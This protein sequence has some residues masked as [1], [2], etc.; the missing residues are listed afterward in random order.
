MQINYKTQEGWDCLEHCLMSIRT[1]F[2]QERLSIIPP[3]QARPNID[4]YS[5]LTNNAVLVWTSGEIQLCWLICFL[6]DMLYVF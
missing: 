6:L 5:I 4:V 3:R 1:K 2:I